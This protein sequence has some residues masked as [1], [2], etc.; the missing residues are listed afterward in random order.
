MSICYRTLIALAVM[1]RAALAQDP[2]PGIELPTDAHA[3][4]KTGAGGFV[5]IPVIR[6][7]PQL[8]FGVGAVGAFL[9]SVD[10]TAPQS[11]IGAGGVYSDTQSWMFA[12][13]SRVYFHGVS[14][15]G[16]AG[17]AFFGLNYDFFG[18]GF[19]QGMGDQSVRINQTGDA[20]MVEMLGQLIGPFYA[21]P[22]YLH[23]GVT[24]SPKELIPGNPISALAQTEDAYHVSALGIETSYDTRDDQDSPHRGTYAEATAMFGRGW[25][26]S[27]PQFNFYRGWINQYIAVTR[28]AVLALRLTGCSVDGTAP[29]WEEC[30]YGLDSDL[31][32]YAAGRFRDRTMFTTQGEFRL[33]VWGPVGVALFG[34]VGAVASSFSSVAGNQLL[35]SGG[36]GARYDWT[37]FYHLHLGADVAWGRNGAAFYL[38]LGEA[39]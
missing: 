4:I 37:E 26:D 1:S 21:G 12:V 35:P 18:V 11:V 24:T 15:A 34:G 17:A 6:S 27:D 38:R 29:V 13:G 36:V 19:D 14:R 33:P 10:S 28:A 7:T 20:E 16:A 2:T 9:F 25:L 5:G 39:F 23:R 22:R 30:L 32:G 8:G 31:R 3:P